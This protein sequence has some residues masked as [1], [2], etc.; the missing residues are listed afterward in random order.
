MGF[1]EGKIALFIDGANCHGAAR[2]LGLD[3]DYRK[4]P[5]E[6]ENRIK[7]LRAFY[8]TAVGEDAGSRPDSMIRRR[9]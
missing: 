2:A 4:L 6:F 5:Q 9:P 3:V 7:I 1:R 8:Y